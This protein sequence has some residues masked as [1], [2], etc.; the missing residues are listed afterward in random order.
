MASN[1]LGGYN[2]RI[3]RVSLNDGK[4]SIDEPPADYYQ[5]YIGGRGFIVTTLLKE[6]PGGIDPLGPENKLIFALGPITGM[7][8]MG[9][10]RNS[11]GAKSPLTGAFGEAE[12]GGF[13]GAELKRAG[14]DG[15]IIEGISSAPVYLWIDN[16]KAELRD[17]SHLWGMEVAKTHFEIQKELED[18]KVRTAVIGPGG[19]RLIRFASISNDITHVAARTGLGAV[20]GSKKLKAIA[21]KGDTIPPMANPEFVRNLSQQMAQSFKEKTM[22]WKYGTGQMMEGFSLAGNLPTF[23]FRDGC[24]DDVGKITAQAICEQF[25]VEM[26]GC[27]ACAIR[28]K[29]RIKIDAPWYVDPIYGGPEYETLGA[30]GSNCGIS[31]PK[32]ICKAHEIC[33]KYG[34]DTISAGNTI[35]F[36][37]E[38]FEKG[39]LTTKETDGL[40]LNFGNADS[41]LKI[42]E[43]IVQRE[44]LGAL[45]CE[46]SR[47]AAKHIGKGSEDFAIHVKGMEVPMHDPRLKQGLGLHYSVSPVGAEHVAGI[48]DPLFMSGPIFEEWCGI[49][50]AEP[51]PST[52][53]SSR[54]ARLLYHNGLW[55]HLQNYLVTCALVP[56]TKKQLCET[57][58]AVTG[59]PMSYWRL[60][61]TTERGLTLAKIF[62]IREGFTEKDDVL[63]KRMGTS[64]TRGNLKGVIVDP[65][66]LSE[67]KKVYY[68]MLGWDEHGIPTK[69]RLIE[70][71]IEWA[72][73]HLTH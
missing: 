57:V 19:E 47:I 49:D 46:G 69:A 41:M 42:L 33:N 45:L 34:I 48:Q 68:Q 72:A 18:K 9:S 37:M 8:L 67:A 4:I 70:L 52:E 58:E 16:G 1:A 2:G 28:C 11:V 15:V 24:F 50:F 39:I 32:A 65:D 43:Q 6:V 59:W 60:M 63:P 12:G 64:Q 7:P 35:A 38:C 56:F 71:D 22:V 13:W 10:G 26:Y 14:F 29:K 25:G 17:A 44:G 21:V 53:L 55:G 66:K 54:K 27:Y 23:N 30:F 20:M 31:D 3:L 5:R 40:E 36:A 51:V 62:N 61:K 73:E